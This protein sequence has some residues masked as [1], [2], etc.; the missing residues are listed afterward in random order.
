MERGAPPYGTAWFRASRRRVADLK[1]PLPDVG[2]A[3]AGNAVFDAFVD[4]ELPSA[5]AISTKDDC[6]ALHAIRATSGKSGAQRHHR[7]I[8]EGNVTA[9]QRTLTNAPHIAAR[10]APVST[11]SGLS[12]NGLP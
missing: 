1:S 5:A 7:E 3:G 11:N 9:H 8:R 6:F 10:P 2:F 4:H 12:Q